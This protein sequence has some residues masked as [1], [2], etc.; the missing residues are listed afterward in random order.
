MCSAPASL[1]QSES[2][3]KMISSP[4]VLFAVAAGL[5][6]CLTSTGPA[7]AAPQNLRI[8]SCRLSLDEAG[9]AGI[10]GVEVRVGNPADTLEIADPAVRRKYKEDMARTGLPIS[11]FMMGL[12]NQAPLASDPRGPAWLEQSIDAAKD[13]KVPVI[14]VAFFGKG[15]LRDKG[16]LKAADVDAVV[17]RV[18]AAAPRAAAAGVILALE[19]TLSA[20]QNIEILRR[21]DHPAV[22][23]YYDVGNSTYNGY[24][25]PREIRML[26]D[27]IACIHFK[28]KNDFLGAG[29]VKFEPIAAAIKAIGY[30]GWIV[31]EAAH[32]SKD[33]VADTKR[34]AA[35]IRDLFKS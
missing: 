27:R 24:D 31:L 26:G 21:I 29:Q 23:L 28:D 33:G 20:E 30:K 32:P 9:R 19:N 10:D 6:L 11:S 25:V 5:L 17:K 1:L 4:R 22:K 34:N 16:Q 13:L 15:D 35:F 14:L 18:K 7:F 12:L 3:I 2:P 8:G